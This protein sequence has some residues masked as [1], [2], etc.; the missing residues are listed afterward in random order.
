[1]QDKVTR[2]W[3][4]RQLFLFTHPNDLK[5]DLSL[6]HEDVLY[7]LDRLDFE[8]FIPMPSQYQGRP[9][10]DRCAI[11]RS[12]VAKSILN[13]ATT[14]SLIDRLEADPVLRRLMGWERKGDIPSESTFS[15]A[16]HEFSKAKVLELIHE[17]LIKTTYENRIIG[18]V[19]RDSTSIE[20]R[21]KPMHKP[22]NTT[23]KI[24]QKRGRKAKGALP[25]S[26]P[27]PTRLAK[28]L[29]QTFAEMLKDLPTACDKAGKKD[30]KGNTHYWNGYKLHIDTADG[31]VPISAILTSASV[32]DSQVAIPLSIKS[33][34]RT[35]NIFYEL[36]DAAYDA[37][38]IIQHIEANGSVPLIDPNNRGSQPPKILAPHEKQRY[39]QRS[40]AERTN[41]QLKDNFG[42]S[43]LRV[44]GGE[45]VFTH[46]MFGVLALA[47]VQIGRL[48]I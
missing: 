13:C 23:V 48:L 38:E 1:M 20:A 47:V 27:E 31:D 17:H 6:K 12:F 34:H 44:R 24:P 19:S 5:A 28:Q 3:I 42:G 10:E 22:K 35:S 25:V 39:K 16:F 41:S 45:K 46:L 15:R 9:K 43:N 33:R 37:K 26:L 30:S 29:N 2:P 32:H 11:L 40:S 36:M 21:E 18:H 14:R 7:V 8:Q 4:S